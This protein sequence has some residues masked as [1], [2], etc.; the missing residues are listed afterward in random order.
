[1]VAT[2]AE[3]ARDGHDWV[4][5]DVDGLLV[6]LTG[7]AQSEAMRFAALTAAQTAT[8]IATTPVANRVEKVKNR[9]D[10]RING[11]FVFC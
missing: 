10:R 3:L 6:R 7:T 1:M 2:E 4:L 8:N 9:L 11:L 5:V